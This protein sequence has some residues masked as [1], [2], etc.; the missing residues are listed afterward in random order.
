MIRHVRCPV[1]GHQGSRVLESRGSEE[2]A[3]VRRRRQC[4]S[5]EHRFTTYERCDI[6]ALFV[7]K[8]DGRRQPFDRDKLRGGLERAAHKRPVHA[9]AI[10]ALADRIEAAAV[11]AGGEIT[12]A[13]V[14]EMCLSGLRRIDQVAYLQFAAVYR[15]LDVSDVQAELDSLTPKMIP[16]P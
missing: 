7:L 14:G 11:R 1:C 5:C 15:Q 2:G 9:G 10:D 3:S 12:A 6:Q 13:R 4:S 8:R 16:S